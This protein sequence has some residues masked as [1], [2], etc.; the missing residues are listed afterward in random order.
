MNT[1]LRK[2]K[3]FQTNWKSCLVF[4]LLLTYQKEIQSNVFRFETH[5]VMCTLIINTRLKFRR[6]WSCPR[7]NKLLLIWWRHVSPYCV[8]SIL[9]VFWRRC[10]YFLEIFYNLLEANEGKE[11][12][13]YSL[14]LWIYPA[15]QHS[16]FWFNSIQV[17]W[18]K[19]ALLF[20]WWLLLHSRIPF[21]FIFLKFYLKE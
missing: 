1:V 20:V 5:K 14:C 18:A 21:F 10:L 3:F 2:L 6:A 9:S 13:G 7:I 19:F 11:K 8:I 12:R 4:E 17:W 15:N 16:H